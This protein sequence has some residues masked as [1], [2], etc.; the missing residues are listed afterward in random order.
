MKQ[1]TLSLPPGYGKSRGE[2]S[3][4]QKV[5]EKLAAYPREEER[6]DVSAGAVQGGLSSL[7]EDSRANPLTEFQFPQITGA[8][9]FHN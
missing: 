1:V 2:N 6:E 7:Q 8:H 3:P 5:R 9:G 4:L